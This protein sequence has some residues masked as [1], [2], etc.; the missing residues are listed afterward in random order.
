MTRDQAILSTELARPGFQLIMARLNAYADKLGEEYD[1]VDFVAEPGRAMHIQVTRDVIQNGIPK[2]LED[3]MNIDKP[4][5]IPR[6]TVKG[7]LHGL[8]TLCLV[9]LLSG[10]VMAAGGLLEKDGDNRPVNGAAP[11]GLY[12]A[13]LT[14]NSTTTDMS[15][16]IWW[17]VYAPST[18]CKFRLTP[19]AAKGSYPAFTVPDGQVFGFIV[20]KATPFLNL[21]G[22]T[23]AERYRQHP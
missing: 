10:P 16:D 11:N 18:G 7:W 12:S 2:I 22:C 23:S 9:C 21:S 3:I 14:V 15:G 4:I 5:E 20:N 6:W 19:T 1:S 13:I 8:F 17:G